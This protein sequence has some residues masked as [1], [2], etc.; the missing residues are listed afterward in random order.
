ML[1]IPCVHVV[2]T[3]RYIRTLNDKSTLLMMT[4]L[5]SNTYVLL[6]LAIVETTKLSTKANDIAS[7]FISSFLQNFLQHLPFKETRPQ[8]GVIGTLGFYNNLLE[9]PCFEVELSYQAPYK[10]CH[11]TFYKL[12]RHMI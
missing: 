11:L 10:P 12:F 3:P 8:V 2:T 9:P 5:N 4:V 7:M 6:L 1:C